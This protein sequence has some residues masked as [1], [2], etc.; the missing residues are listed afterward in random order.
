[1]HPRHPGPSIKNLH[2]V[3]QDRAYSDHRM[4]EISQSLSLREFSGLTWEKEKMVDSEIRTPC[5][6]RLWEPQ[7]VHLLHERTWQFCCKQ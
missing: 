7:H 2:K 5:M 6:S 4:V 3:G 1:M